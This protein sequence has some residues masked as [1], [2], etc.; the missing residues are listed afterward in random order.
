MEYDRLNLAKKFIFQ[1]YK[2]SKELPP[3]AFKEWAMTGASE[4]IG[5]D[6]GIW[7]DGIPPYSI[8]SIYLFNQPPE[9]LQSYQNL[10][11]SGNRDCLAEAAIASPN[12]VVIREHEIKKIDYVDGFSEHCE[13]FNIRQS[14]SMG[15]LKPEILLFSGLSYYRKDSNHYFSADDI[16][17][18]LLIDPHMRE[19]FETCLFINLSRRT[20]RDIDINLYSQALVNENGQITYCNDSFILNW[21]KIKRDFDK[22]KLPTELWNELKTEGR[23]SFEDMSFTIH[24]ISES[25]WSVEIFTEYNLPLS[26][27]EYEVAMKLAMGDSYKKIGLMLG[28]SPKT[29]QNQASSIYKKLGI[30]NKSELA[31]TLSQAN[32]TI[33]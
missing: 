15:V 3:S 32:I 12:E 19:A 27:S 2:K 22:C 17:L 13:L 8:V 30:S 25:E 16:A 26:N 14:C 18:K 31:I 10:L 5:F 33:I 20:N 9:M 1:L 11:M 6:S 29:V 24:R 28:K 4:I 7:V 23:A 21:T